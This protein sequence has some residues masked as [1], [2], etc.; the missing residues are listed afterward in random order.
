MFCYNVYIMSETSKNIPVEYRESNN[1]IKLTRRGKA[2]VAAGGIVLAG[3][4]LAH[5][6]AEEPGNPVGH[7]VGDV[8]N[9][10]VNIIDMV[11]GVDIAD[12]ETPTQ[13]QVEGIKH[14]ET[15]AE[16]MFVPDSL[17][18][19]YTQWD[20]QQINNLSK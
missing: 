1:R 14:G 15:N 5:G 20:S 4:A 8:I 7:L 12:I 11:P 13:S 16:D 17:S 18:Q 10:G 9:T 6:I 3:A 2:A 19:D